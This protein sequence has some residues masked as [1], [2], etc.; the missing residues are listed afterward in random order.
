MSL[1][2]QQLISTVAPHCAA[3]TATQQLLLNCYR[4]TLLSALLQAARMLHYLGD[5]ILMLTSMNLR[6]YLRLKV[7]IQGTSGEGSK[8]VKAFRSYCL[9]FCVVMTMYSPQSRIVHNCPC[10]FMK[11]KSVYAFCQFSTSHLSSHIL[12]NTAH[13]YYSSRLVFERNAAVQRPVECIFFLQAG[14]SWRAC[15][16]RL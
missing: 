2:I 1:D 12:F 6:D 5:H 13:A 10:T 11:H 4:M 9:C 14:A 3:A 15:S 7:E 8:A 16:S